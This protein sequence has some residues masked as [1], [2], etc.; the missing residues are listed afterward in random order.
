MKQ[1]PLFV[2]IGPTGVGKTELGLKIALEFN[3]P[4][5]SADSR[6]IYKEMTIGTA[7]PSEEE[8]KN[9]QHYFIATKS[10]NEDYNA[11]TYAK[12]CL[13]LLNK[14]YKKH[15]TPPCFAIL[16]G[17]SML[18]I[19]AVCYGL[20]NIPT[21][22]QQIKQ[23]TL[24]LY[25][26]YGINWLQTQIQKIDPLYWNEVDKNNT[27]RLMH[28]LEVYTATGIPYSTYRKK[29]NLTPNT[30]QTNFPIIKIGLQRNREQLYQ[31]INNRVDL[32]FEQGLLD[33]AQKL[34]NTYS[35]LSPIPNSLLSVGYR[36]LFDYFKGHLTLEQTKNLIKQNSRHYAK[37]QMT[38]WRKQKEIK[39]INATDNYDN[40]KNQILHLLNF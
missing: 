26:K 17:G 23:Q 37:R 7:S 31:R 22:S 38:W 24:H 40:I 12:D 14:L 25:Q 32:M 27:A 10:V 35:H 18:Y 30:H 36:E 13:N 29:M 34:Y 20:D 21:T 9:I 15:N 2:L 1:Q 3:L 33:E 4:L 5:V 19:D 11:G 28:C 39:W 16:L 8:L 6:Q